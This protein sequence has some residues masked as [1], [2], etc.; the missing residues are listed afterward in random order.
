MAHGDSQ[1]V[2][3]TISQP[4]QW[5]PSAFTYLTIKLCPVLKYMYRWPHAACMSWLGRIHLIKMNIL[6]RLLYSFQMVPLL[7][8]RKTFTQLDRAI[9]CFI[10]P[11]KTPRLRY[12]YLTLPTRLAGLAVPSHKCYQLASQLSFIE[13]IENPRASWLNGESA[14][15]GTIPLRKL[16]YISQTKIGK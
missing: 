6:P 15:I 12:S 2:N 1:A 4:F 14:T 7:L 11:R 3:S 5:P 13:S 16:L 8:P 9:I 10:W